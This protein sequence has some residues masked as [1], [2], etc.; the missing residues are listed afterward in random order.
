MKEINT[1]SLMLGM[2]ILVF[3]IAVLFILAKIVVDIGVRNAKRASVYDKI[4]KNINSLIDS[5][6]VCEPNYVWLMS[7]IDYLGALDYKDKKRTTDLTVK[8]LR[9]YKEIAEKRAAE[10]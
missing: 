8:F 6:E 9:K 5:N 3:F 10:N 4:Y 2:F 7:L 1:D